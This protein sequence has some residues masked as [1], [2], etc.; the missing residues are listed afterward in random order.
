MLVA[1]LLVVLDWLITLGLAHTLRLWVW[2]FVSFICLIWCL[3]FACNSLLVRLV[4]VGWFWL[5][6]VCLLVVALRALGCCWV[7]YSVV[8]D[9]VTV[10][11][12]NSVVFLM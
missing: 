2:V 6:G 7:C 5:L 4:L 9:L 1:R 10:T 11:V 12:F 8:I 3:L